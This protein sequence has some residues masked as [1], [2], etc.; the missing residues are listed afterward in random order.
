MRR[1]YYSL[2]VLVISNSV[3]SQNNAS[4]TPRIVDEKPT[5]LEQY[6]WGFATNKTDK[7]KAKIDFKAIDN[8]KGFGDY[9]SVSNNGKYFAYTVASDNPHFDAFVKLDSLI[10]QSID[11]SYRRS[12]TNAQ[13]GFFT[14]D[15]K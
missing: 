10:V 5:G 14:A 8:W 7:A 11:L 15:N 3:F 6:L 13:P 9:L 4:P 12:F 1:L 2:I